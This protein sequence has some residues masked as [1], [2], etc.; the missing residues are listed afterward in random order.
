MQLNV[1]LGDEMQRQNL[2]FQLDRFDLNIAEGTLDDRSRLGPALDKDRLE[3]EGADLYERDEL[4][5]HPRGGVGLYLRPGRYSRLASHLD[6]LREGT[7]SARYSSFAEIH[8][9]NAAK[10]DPRLRPQSS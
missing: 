6:A 3:A 10:V 4:P 1:D 7:N 2:Q 9:R 5:P 8:K